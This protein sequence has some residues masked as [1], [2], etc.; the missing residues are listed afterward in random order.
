MPVAR[1]DA[2][3][4]PR[5]NERPVL[6]VGQRAGARV[7]ARH[8]LPVQQL[9][10]VHR[11]APELL[12]PAEPVE[13]ALQ[14][15]HGHPV[16]PGDE[17]LEA[18]VQRV[19]HPEGP[20]VAHLVRPGPECRGV[21]APGVGRHR[22]PLRQLERDEP[23]VGGALGAVDELAEAVARLAGAADH[24]RLARQAAPAPVVP[25]APGLPAQVVPGAAGVVAGQ[26]L[27]EVGPVHLEGVAPVRGQPPAHNLAHPHPHVPRRVQRHAHAPRRLAQGQLVG[28]A[29]RELHP[30]LGPQL[31]AAEQAHGGGAERPGAARAQPPLASG[32]VAALPDEPRAPAPRAAV[33]IAPPG[34]HLARY[35]RPELLRQI[36]LLGEREPP[37]LLY[38]PVHGA[39]VFDGFTTSPS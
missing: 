8:L 14:P 4:V 3:P 30:G 17:R 16:E 24:A 33:G 28:H 29:G 19:G 2:V 22:A 39:S 23:G 9:A 12:A 15:A 27:G 10:A 13:V 1:A 20:A 36:S 21:A 34:G 32:A 25:R 7:G 26:R 5:R 31:R 11:A 6:E 35:R 18:G 37:D 38:N